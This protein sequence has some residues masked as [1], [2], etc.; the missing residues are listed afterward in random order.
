MLLHEFQH[1]SS[2]VQNVVND[3][4]LKPPNIIVPKG[5]AGGNPATF[6][7]MYV[8]S[9]TP[10]FYVCSQTR[11]SCNRCMAIPPAQKAHNAQN[12]AFFAIDVLADPTRGHPR[13]KTKRIVER[14]DAI[15]ERRAEEKKKE[16]TKA[17][18][19]TPDKKVTGK[20]DSK[21]ATAGQN[22]AAKDGYKPSASKVKRPMEFSFM[23][24]VNVDD[25]GDF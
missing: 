9:F 5:T 23:P 17:K 12:V 16:A 15:N 13:P 2:A 10:P 7:N 1:A 20:A 8:P 11:S 21:A 19:A 6:V 25:A 14:F 4:W 18:A 22:N 3:I 24:P